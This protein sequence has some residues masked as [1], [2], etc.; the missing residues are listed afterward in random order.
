MLKQLHKLLL[1][2][3]TILLMASCHQTYYQVLET[4]STD[5]KINSS[6]NAYETNE[7][8]VS[9][10]FWSNGGDVYF[11]L[12]NKLDVPIYIDWNK[13]HLIYN[14]VSYDYWNDTEETNSFYS[15]SAVTTSNTFADAMTN[16]FRNSAYSS[17]H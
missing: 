2:I 6:N 16:I 10:N 12:T 3:S 14:G 5:A 11:Q 17:G 1:T 8:K 9:Y 4:L 7:L 15:S 13:S